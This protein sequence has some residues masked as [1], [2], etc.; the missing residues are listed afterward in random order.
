MVATNVWVVVLPEFIVGLAEL[1]VTATATDGPGP[2]CGGAP[3]VAVVIAALPGTFPT[4]VKFTVPVIGS[5]LICTRKLML[6]EAP[7][8]N[9]PMLQLTAIVDVVVQVPC[10]G[11]PIR[12]D[13][14]SV[15]VRA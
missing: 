10:P 14:P 2:P 1:A 11:W 9:D 13:A 3:G 12:T 6:T 15:V 7:G 4:A 8:A 5:V